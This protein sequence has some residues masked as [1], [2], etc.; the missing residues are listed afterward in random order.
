M[1]SSKVFKV[2][3]KESPIFYGRFEEG[4]TKIQFYKR[5]LFDRYVERL[6]EYAK[7]RD[8]QVTMKLRSKR[9]SLAENAYY[10]AVVVRMVAEEM[11]VLDDEA[12]DYMKN[13]FL[14]I[15]VTKGGKRFELPRSTTRLSTV[16]FEEYVAKCRDWAGKE[17]NC[18]VPE[19]N[20]VEF[21]PKLKSQKHGKTDEK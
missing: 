14:K 11:G 5:E 18:Y 20:E 8:I 15:G 2:I 4:S 9:R 6:K 1:A 12:H 19:P 3:M 17:L 7:G 10:W 21:Q 13:L 16:E